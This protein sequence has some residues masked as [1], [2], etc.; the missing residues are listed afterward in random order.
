M[1]GKF[2]KLLGGVRGPSSSSVLAPEVPSCQWEGTR[3]LDAYI[4]N[5]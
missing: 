1:T 4:F 2:G 5:A 3:A